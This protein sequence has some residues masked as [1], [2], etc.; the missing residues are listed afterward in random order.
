MDLVAADH[1]RAMIAF[2]KSSVESRGDGRGALGEARKIGARR[3]HDRSRSRRW[4]GSPA[5]RARPWPG[6]PGRRER[7][8]R[9]E[10]ERG[11]MGVTLP[12]AHLAREQPAPDIASRT[13]PA[14]S[15]AGTSKASA[16]ARLRSGSR[17]PPQPAGS[18]CGGRPPPAICA[19]PAPAVRPSRADRLQRVIELE[20]VD[21]ALRLELRPR[22]AAKR[23]SGLPSSSI[24]SSWTPPR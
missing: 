24:T 3:R 16:L 13:P 15:A 11:D 20:V 12:P 18:T 21:V 22:S 10:D 1:R 7:A 2:R 5:R 17:M 4:P 23:G 14:S 6:R 8:A 19:P 9:G